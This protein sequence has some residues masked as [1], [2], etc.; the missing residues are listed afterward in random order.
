ML[1]STRVARVTA[2]RALRLERAP[3]AHLVDPLETNADA[4]NRWI[5][6]PA[7]PD[8]L[9]DRAGWDILEHMMVG[10]TRGDSDPSSP[11]RDERASYL[12]R[13]RG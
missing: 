1:L 7:G 9:I 13:S 5:F 8:R 11:D 12:L 3:V 6:S 4:T 2:D 10:R